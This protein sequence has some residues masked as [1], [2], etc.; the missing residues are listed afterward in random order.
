MNATYSCFITTTYIK[1]NSPVI[2]Y[3]SDNELVVFIKPVQEEHI[4]RV[5]GTNLMRD[6][7]ANMQ[8]GTLS[9][10]YKTLLTD[11]IQYATMY[12]VI[13]EFLLWSQ[14]K[15]TNKSITTQA[16][17]NST[18]VD[19]SAVDRLLSNARD[20]AEYYSDRAV[21]W[22]R[23]NSSQFPLYFGGTVDEST[24][25]PKYNSFFSGIYTGKGKG[26]YECDG[27]ETHASTYIRIR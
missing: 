7:Q 3:V 13:Y 14:Y 15:I 19:Q 6:I 27:I 9:D 17:D 16:S 2:D 10:L 11:H 4:I 25:V 8:A 20:K 21:K 26:C 12:W 18:A 5:L 22:I 23:A 1:N 24:I